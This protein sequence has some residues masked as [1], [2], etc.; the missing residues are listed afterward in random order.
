MRSIMP[1]D[2]LSIKSIDFHFAFCAGFKMKK[3][4]KIDEWCIVLLSTIHKYILDFI[5]SIKLSVSIFLKL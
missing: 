4:E 1:M 3:C 2:S 5:I